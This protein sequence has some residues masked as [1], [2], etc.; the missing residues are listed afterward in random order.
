MVRRKHISIAVVVVIALAIAAIASLAIFGGATGINGPTKLTLT[1]NPTVV[2]MG[3]MQ[4]VMVLS[5]SNPPASSAYVYVARSPIF[6]SRTLNVTV[7]EGTP[8]KVNAGTV[9]ANMELD[10][11]SIS[12]N[13]VD[14]TVTPIQAYLAEQPDS[15]KISV[16]ANVGHPSTSV[17]ISGSTSVPTSTTT[18]NQSVSNSQRTL[19]LLKRTEYYPLMANYSDDFA[20][21]AN[22][23]GNMYNTSYRLTYRIAPQGPF[24]YQN[25]TL[26]TPYAITLNISGAGNGN[27]QAVYSTVAHTS[28]STGPALTI[29]FNLTTGL[30]ANTIFS[31][32]WKGQ[33]YSSLVTGL[34]DAA[35]VG[36]SCGILVY[37]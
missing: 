1:S 28:F 23:T 6:V 30:I 7:V 37:V 5:N 26:V 20:N 34:N 35:G 21:S 9:Y 12:N 19:E 2:Q 15:G 11:N 17:P 24:T 29:E 18:I 22:C 4:Y 25:I 10:L 16:V 14:V 33:S 27:W 31:G 13:S 3:G 8:T 32:A 36:N